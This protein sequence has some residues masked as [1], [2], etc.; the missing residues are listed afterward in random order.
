MW[1]STGYGFTFYDWNIG[2]PNNDE[3]QDYVAVEWS[4]GVLAW[5]DLHSTLPYSPLCERVGVL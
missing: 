4:L 3:N 2:Q 5:N 1:A